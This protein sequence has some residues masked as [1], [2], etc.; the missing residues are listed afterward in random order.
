MFNGIYH[1]MSPKH[2]HR[3]V[4]EFAGRHNVRE[5]DTLGQ[6]GRLAAGMAGKRLTYRRL[7]ADNGLPSGA[8]G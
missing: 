1:K 2:L 3:Y 6:M 4:S 8:R 7:N 5:H